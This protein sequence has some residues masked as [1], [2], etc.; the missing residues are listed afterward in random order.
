MINFEKRGKCSHNHCSKMSNSAWTDLNN[1][2]TILKLHD[3]CPKCNCQ[4]ILSFSPYQYQMEG[5]SIKTKLKKYLKVQKQLG[6]N[7]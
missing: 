3:K 5:G 4:K 7:F 1:N 6:I 2:N